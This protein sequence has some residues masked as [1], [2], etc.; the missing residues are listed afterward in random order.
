MSIVSA[1]GIGSGLE[2]NAIVKQLVSVEGQP[3]FNSINRQTAAAN[4]RLSGLGSLRSALADFADSV[5]KL[6][7]GNS[8]RPHTVTSSDESRIRVATGLGAVA[9][10][11]AIEVVK[12]ATAQ[13]SIANTG[14]ASP[15]AT[16]GSGSLTFTPGSGSAFTVTVDASNNSLQGIRDSINRADGNSFVNASIINVDDG[17]GGTVSRLVL[18]ARNPGIGSAFTVGGA[19]SDGNDTDTAGLSGLF[20]ANLTNQTV[21]DN[22]VIRVDGQTATRSSN[23]ISDVISGLTLDL[24]KAEVGATVNVNVALDTQAIEKTVG[25]FV[26]AYNKLQSTARNLGRHGGSGDGVGNGP[27]LGDASLRLVTG[28]I[29]QETS[30]PVS[31]APS[32]FNSLAQIGITINKD[33]VMALDNGRL[34]TALTSNLQSVAEVFTSSEG[35]ANRLDKRLDSV[36]QS[37]GALD[38]QQTSLRD[39]LSALTRRREDVQLRLDKLEKSLL[40]QFTAMDVAVGRFNATGSFLSSWIDKQ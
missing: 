38:R 24:R 20:S 15:A 37:G 8:F 19:D 10:N 29:R 13:K 18:T 27:L 21:A 6:K 11:Y 4:T 23:S 16:V 7:D 14:Y 35:V 2:I 5:N 28:Q 39:Q 26:T 12:L 30:A 25:D 1:T 17:L 40:K 3:A 34:R 9:G 22:A 31:S 32:H 36:L 33:G